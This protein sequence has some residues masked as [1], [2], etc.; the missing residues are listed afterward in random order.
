MMHVR[1]DECD[2]FGNCKRLES[3]LPVLAEHGMPEHALCWLVGL[4]DGRKV[5]VSDMITPHGFRIAAV[6]G[7]K[8][9]FVRVD[10]DGEEID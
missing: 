4:I 5:R 2:G 6:P 1:C 9:K 7:E 10:A 8:L 3:V